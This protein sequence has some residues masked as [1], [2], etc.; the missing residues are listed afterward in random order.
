MKDQASQYR[1][2]ILVLNKAYIQKNNY[3]YFKLFRIPEILNR[4]THYREILNEK[5]INVPLWVYSLIQD[6]KILTEWRQP[7][8]LNFLINLG[9]FERYISYNGWP[10]YIIGSDPLISVIEGKVSFEEQ[11]LLLSHGYSQDSP[12]LQ[13]YKVSSYYNKQTD[14]FCLNSLKKQSV[15]HSMEDFL[16]YFKFHLKSD[17]RDWF[18]QLLSPHKEEFMDELESKGAVVRDFL[19]F[20]SS[21]KWLW[22]SWKKF[23]LKAL[24]DRSLQTGYYTDPV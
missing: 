24:R 23:Q 7:F 3:F 5:G 21:L 14:S 15:G 13:L 4:L 12:K 1:K 8:I 9:L 19:E 20:D 18:F 17:W 11:V 2:D 22:P 16:E 10:Q 6:L